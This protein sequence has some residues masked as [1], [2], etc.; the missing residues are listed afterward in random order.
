[1]KKLA[2]LAAA[3]ALAMSAGPAFAAKKQVVIVVKGLD[4]PFFEAINQGCQKWNSENKDSEYEC[5]YTGPA[6]TSDEAG[7]AQIVQDVLGKADTAAIAISPSNAKLIAQTLKV[8]APSIPVMT[9]DADLSP[10]DASL[11]KTYLGTD[12]YLMGFKIGEYVKKGKP[13]GGTVCTI[14]GN[15]GADNILRR[16][17]G[18]RDALSGQKGIAALAGEGG[19]TEV[20]GC[21]VFTNDDGAKGVQAMTDILAANPKLDAFG[22][23]GGWP[24]FGAPQ[25][26]RDLVG[27]L[28]DRIASSD[29]VIGAADT[30][31]A[32]VD[33]AKEG[34]VN[35]LVGQRPFEM[36]YKAPSVMIDLIAGKK[37][38][39]PVFTGL[40]ECTKDTVDTCIQR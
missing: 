12:N 36:G 31:G 7:E 15:P 19:W 14:Q 2:L 22:I 37:V 32:E 21:P 5:F 9:L 29:F 24:L 25:P 33:I 11:R 30:I 20:S 38:E 40:D 6:S 3:A 17:Q 39:D 8:A 10:D 16:A 4:N 27:P 28:K 34:L 13:N 35:A 18:F 1:M 26:Y 23:M